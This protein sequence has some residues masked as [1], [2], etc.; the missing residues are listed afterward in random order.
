[1]MILIRIFFMKQV[2]IFGLPYKK[3]LKDFST[4]M[5]AKLKVLIANFTSGKTVAA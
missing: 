3:K 1:M 4:G 5:K 2:E